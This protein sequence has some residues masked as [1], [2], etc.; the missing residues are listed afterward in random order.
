MDHV[1]TETYSGLLAKWSTYAAVCLV[2]MVFYRL[3]WLTYPLMPLQ[4]VVTYTS[5]VRHNFVRVSQQPLATVAFRVHGAEQVATLEQKLA[6]NAVEAAELDRLRNEV[7]ALSKASG[8]RLAGESG[9]KIAASVIETDK[10]S[11]KVKVGEVDE[12]ERGMYVLD[13]VGVVVGRVVGVNTFFAIVELPTAVNSRI[14]VKVQGRDTQGVLVGDGARAVLT[15]V[16]QNE[17]LVPGDVIVTLGSEGLFP[18]GLVVGTVGEIQSKA[19]DATQ[20]AKVELLASPEYLV[21]L[22]N[23]L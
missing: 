19:A 7:A 16:L 10:T 23:S 8:L 12:V 15:E 21:I 14:G 5:Q 6:R 11:M 13:E 22:R 17:T 20:Q 4:W 9:R 1:R 2:L 3:A 18:A